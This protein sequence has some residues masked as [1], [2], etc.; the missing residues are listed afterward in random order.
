[1]TS[2]KSPDVVPSN[3]LETTLEAPAQQQDDDADEK[4]VVVEI[5]DNDDGGSIDVD[6]AEID[7]SK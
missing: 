1:M 5:D 6:L 3:Q 7:V 2:A 4:P